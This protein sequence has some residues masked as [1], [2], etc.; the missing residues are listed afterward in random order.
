MKTKLLLVS[1]LFLITSC[2]NDYG[3]KLLFNGTEV[4]YKNGVTKEQATQ[5]GEYLVKEEFATGGS[6]SVQLVI[7][8]ETKNLTFRMVVDEQ[9]ANSDSNDYIF[10][11]FSRE[12]T[13]EFSQPVDFELCDNTFTTLKIYF[14][15]DVSKLINAKKTQLLYTKNITESEAQ[16]LADYLIESEFADDENE[17]TIELDKENDNYI[18]KMAVYKGAENNE[19]NIT[20]LGMFAKELSENVFD[21]TPV[22]LH[23]CDDTMSTIKIIG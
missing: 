4:Y 21:N 15:K 18:F 9:T 17:K 16:K 22:K 1:I 23:M 5:L 19:A 2:T 14:N 20:L 10:N 11:S 13:K 3:E 8:D 6:K 7:N 12:L